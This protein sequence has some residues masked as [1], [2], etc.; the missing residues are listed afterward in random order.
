VHTQV[1][2]GC[3]H[4]NLFGAHA[5]PLVIGNIHDILFNM[6]SAISHF[7]MHNITEMRTKPRNL[8]NALNTRIA[9]R[10][11]SR[12]PATFCECISCEARHFAASRAFFF[13]SSQFMS[14]I[15]IPPSNS[16]YPNSEYR[17]RGSILSLHHYVHSLVTT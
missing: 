16:P 5:L 14:R 17:S 7:S 13:P 1:M 15:P 6:T 12:T 2:T 4:E 10:R 3:T 8:S 11:C 9:W